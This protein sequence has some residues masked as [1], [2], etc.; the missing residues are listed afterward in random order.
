MVNHVIP[1]S[2]SQQPQNFTETMPGTISRRRA[3]TEGT[4]EATASYACTKIG[5]IRCHIHGTRGCGT[6]GTIVSCRSTEQGAKS[7]PAQCI[8]LF[9]QRKWF[10][11]GIS[12][13]SIPNR[14]RWIS[15]LM[16]SKCQLWQTK[17]W[18][19]NPINEINL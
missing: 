19:P 3:R 12:T 8:A 11:H 1:R 7:L 2:D 4:G 16:T 5:V 14:Y 15:N 6:G 10:Q 18:T 13:A 9:H 17:N